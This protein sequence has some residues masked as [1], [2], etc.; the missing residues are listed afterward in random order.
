MNAKKILS[1]VLTVTMCLMLVACA[2]TAPATTAPASAET[3]T[4][5]APAANQK[6]TKTYEW[7][8]QST[9]N[10]TIA[11]YNERNEICKKIYE[12]TNGGLKITQYSG[13]A[14]ISDMNIPDAVMT[15]TIQMG[16]VYLNPLYAMV[17]SSN[18][19][20]IL[21]GF[22]F[23]VGNCMLFLQGYGAME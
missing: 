10:E 18:I 4:V 23:D 9:E 16:N 13:G 3:T 5:S 20:G 11:M 21:P 6:P 19:V 14:I 8:F 1:L 12:E 22:L 2:A 7:V 15:G 17:P